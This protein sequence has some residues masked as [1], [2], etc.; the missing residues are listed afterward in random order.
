MIS[1]RDEWLLERLGRLGLPVMV[2]A[3][4]VTNRR[5]PGSANLRT[6]P[7]ASRIGIASSGAGF[8]AAT[9]S[10]AARTFGA[11]AAT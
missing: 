6:A 3:G 7:Y 4:A 9:T 5:V 10:A 2:H 11:A 8:E 1:V